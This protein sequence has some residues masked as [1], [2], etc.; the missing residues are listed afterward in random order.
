MKK[1][2]SI[3]V[4]AVCMLYAICTCGC[5]TATN[6]VGGRSAVC[7]VIANTA[8]S[9]G[10]N[11]NSQFI[12]ETV[13][14][15]IKNY[16][17]IS[18]VSVDG[19]PQVVYA[20]SYDI[21]DRYKNASAEK[22]E[23]DAQVKTAN[24]L[25][26]LCTVVADDPEA[27]YLDA[28][29]LA[30][31]SLSSLVG[32]DSKTIIVIGT[33][34]GTAGLLDFRNNLLAADPD[35]VVNLLD[36]QQA[37]P[38]FTGMLVCWQQMGDVAEPQQ[39]LTPVQRNKLVDIY[40]GIIEKGNGTFSYDSTIAEAPDT[41]CS[42]PPVSV[43]DLPEQIPMVFE[44]ENLDNI[45]D[46]ESDSL[47]DT[48]MILS[49]EQVTFIEDTASY[50]NPDLVAQTVQPIAEWM[51]EHEDVTLLLVGTT[52]GDNNSSNAISLSMNRAEA[53]RNTLIEFGVGSDRIIT[54]G[55]GCEDPWHIYG[56]GFGVEASVNRKVVLID[57]ST[58]Q[59]QEII[60]G[61]A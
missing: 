25:S 7:F 32:Y 47:F 29:T 4:V 13:Y 37:I 49:E 5:S 52:A 19:D 48:P 38:D 53:V 50:L 59:A 43:V 39:E 14:N 28:L 15:T 45:P 23:S 51:I 8:N 35:V 11:T 41:D 9:Q 10:I 17:Y 34:L 61:L 44:Y 57:A 1:I 21:E 22:L 46:S 60:N 18:V 58:Q 55:L 33:G 54:V 36:E 12:Q 3:V 24:L 16:G 40:D 27:D 2:M 6:V 42:Y 56:L 26:A 30:S 31:R 20:N